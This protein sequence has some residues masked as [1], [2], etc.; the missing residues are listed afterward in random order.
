M[1]DFLPEIIRNSLFKKLSIEDINEIRLRVNKPIIVISNQR[2]YYL[3]ENGLCNSVVSSIIA[4]IIRPGARSS[5]TTC[6]TGHPIRYR[7]MGNFRD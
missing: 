3:S 6:I 5:G 2:T 1:I 4:T 7:F